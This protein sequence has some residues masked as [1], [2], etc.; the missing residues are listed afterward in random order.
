MGSVE[1]RGVQGKMCNWLKGSTVSS[2]IR[3]F[4]KWMVCI[5]YIYMFRVSYMKTITSNQGQ[6]QVEVS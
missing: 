6:P 1:F 2:Y 3:E 4:S 5:I